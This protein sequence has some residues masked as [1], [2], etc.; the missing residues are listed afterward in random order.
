MSKVQRISRTFTLR[1]QK[2]FAELSGDFNPFHI[3]ELHSRRLM[4]GDVLVHAV[5]GLLWGLDCWLAGRSNSIRLTSLR[6][7]FQKPIRIE[8]T[9]DYDVKEDVEGRVVIRLLNGSDTA[10]IIEA[11]F[12][13]GLLSYGRSLP[14]AN[15]PLQTCLDRSATELADAHGSLQ[16]AINLR[17]ASD[18]F[19]NLVRV[20]CSVQ[21]AEILASTRLVGMECPGLHSLYSKLDLDFTHSDSSAMKLNYRVKD[22]DPRFSMINIQIGG[23]RMTGDIKAFI[24]PAPQCQPS[25]CEI[26]QEILQH[27]FLGRRAFVVGGSRGIGEVTAKLLAAGGAEVV[28]TYFRGADDACRIVE[29][30]NTNGGTADFIRFNALSPRF[31][32]PDRMAQNW[33]PTHVYYFATPHISAGPKRDFD[34]NL[35]HNFTDYYV[36]GL[37]ETY[38]LFKDQGLK[39]I[40]Y[41]SSIFVEETSPDMSEYTAAK[42]AGEM[43]CR[44]LMEIDADLQIDAPRLPRLATDQTASLL[45]VT[46]EDPVPVMLG[47]LKQRRKSTLKN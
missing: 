31:V 39:Y 1:D 6:V 18:A 17:L 15:P 28:L 9:V 24:R 34:A 21:L 41:P 14:N 3:D 32:R 13:T 47:Y 20:L 36:V 8:E 35:F 43:L 22:L 10:T 4:F 5:H 12:T 30:I 27:A 16:L 25:F 23:P 44:F 46:K 38:K 40:F 26:Q 33:W 11:E 7:I 45:P 19:P 2:V 29:D 42:S 37:M